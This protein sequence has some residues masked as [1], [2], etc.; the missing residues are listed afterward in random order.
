MKTYAVVEITDEEIRKSVREALAANRKLSVVDWVIRDLAAKADSYSR[1]QKCGWAVA[2]LL[3]PAVA[4]QAARIEE[5]VKSYVRDTG[6]EELL[7]SDKTMD[8]LVGQGLVKASRRLNDIA[9]GHVCDEFGLRPGTL[10]RDVSKSEDFARALDE[11]TTDSAYAR[12]A[13]SFQQ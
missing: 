11:S 4:K 12:V 5:I 8:L 13:A 6:A 2:L 10:F 7:L 1:S 9:P 3:Q